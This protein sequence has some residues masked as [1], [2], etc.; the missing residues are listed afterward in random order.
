ML[1]QDQTCVLRDDTAVS[2]Q[3]QAPDLENL[4]ENALK[5]RDPCGAGCRTGCLQSK[6]MITSTLFLI[7]GEYLKL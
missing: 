6:G 7:P 5:H 2:E 3:L 4:K 1:H